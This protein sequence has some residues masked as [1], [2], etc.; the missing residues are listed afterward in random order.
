MSASAL[1]RVVAVLAAVVVV[2]ALRYAFRTVPTA[3]V[4][5][6][7]PGSPAVLER[8]LGHRRSGERS[9]GRRSAVQ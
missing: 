7:R 4:E 5:A 2:L 1:L 6:P 9:R 3:V 8:L